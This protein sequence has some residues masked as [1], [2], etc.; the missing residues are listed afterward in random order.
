MRVFVLLLNLFISTFFAYAQEE[1]SVKK[2]I[3]ELSALADF[4][5]M[6]LKVL[7]ACPKLNRKPPVG[8][9]VRYWH[10]EVFMETVKEPGGSV[11]LEYI[12]LLEPIGRKIATAEL[13]LSSKVKPLYISSGSSISSL[14]V[15]NLQFNEVHLYDFPLGS[16]LKS[17]LCSTFPNNTLGVRYLSELDAV[18][19]RV[20]HAESNLPQS[21]LASRTAAYC[22]ELPL[23][24]PANCMKA[25]GSLYPRVGFTV[26]PVDV[27]ASV[28]NA[29]R[30]VSIAADPKL[31]HI[32]ESPLD[33]R[34]DITRDKVQLIYP[35]RTSC[36]P[37]GEDIQ[38]LEKLQSKDGRYVWIYWH[39]RQCCL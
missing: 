17:S 15:G 34:P 28:I 25:W 38:R 6:D 7:G 10:P 3:I 32:V 27:V 23:G 19:W 2:S 16:F 12:P 26:S 36:F 31:I 35:I 11:I 39:Q 29:I 9:K 21:I 4:S 24:G 22:H 5:C 14:D 13:E 8:V 33:F 20:N 1:A 30:S 18:S 37:V